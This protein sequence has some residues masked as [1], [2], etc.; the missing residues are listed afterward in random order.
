MPTQDD[1]TGAGRRPRLATALPTVL[2]VLSLA[3]AAAYGLRLGTR[4]EI[5]RSAPDFTLR[6]L[7]GRQ[8]T[9]SALRGKAVLLNFWATWC[10]PCRA[11]AFA[12]EAFHRRYGDRVALLGVN[13]R[14]ADQVMRAFAR[15]FGTTYPLLVDASGAVAE[16]YR[17]RA[18]PETWWV[19]REGILRLHHLGAMAFE[20][21]QEAYRRVTGEAIDGPGVGPVT[22]GSVLRAAAW[23]PGGRP[24]Q[25]WMA[26]T[27]G[28]FAGEPA[29]ERWRGLA[30]P[31]AGLVVDLVRTGD[32]LWALDADGQLWRAADGGALQPAGR[33]VPGSAGRASALAVHPAQPSRAAVWVE[34]SGLWL[35]ADGGA[36][37]RRAAGLDGA[38]TVLALAFDPARTGRLL[39]GLPDG[40]VEVDAEAGTAW[41]VEL[42]AAS[43]DPEG[44]MPWDEG[45]PRPVYAIAFSPTR[46]GR[47][48]L[49]TDWGVWL[50]EDGG[51]TLRYLPQSPA[52]II[53]ALS[54]LPAAG[55]LLLAAAPNGDLYAGTE[56]GRAWQLLAP[57]R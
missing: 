57:Q 20:D 56:D 6:D 39:V 21:M 49:A 12:L 38:S 22:G 43:P 40:L 7:E 23:A 54:L 13:L 44:L 16:R 45:F 46:P 48:Y 50:S 2:L 1:A 3:G 17:V 33:P 11:E 35:S 19:D 53:R 37:W 26:T 52:R 5:G 28:L 25:V 24:G 15:M 30:P 41:R 14:E 9:L 34:G 55:E 8:V 18:V 29:T 42:Q 36:R 27:S 4:A 47:I 32:E 10:G 51:H 31:G